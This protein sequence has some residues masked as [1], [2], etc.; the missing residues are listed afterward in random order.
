M[1]LCPDSRLRVQCVLHQELLVILEL[2]V[3]LFFALKA[4]VFHEIRHDSLEFAFSV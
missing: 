3:D 2:L 4:A 1:P